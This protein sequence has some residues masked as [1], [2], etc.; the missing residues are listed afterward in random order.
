MDQLH[1]GPIAVPILELARQPV[2][3]L[4]ENESPHL[5]DQMPRQR[6]SPR[7]DL[8]NLVV[9]LGVDRLDDLSLEV[10]IQEEVLPQ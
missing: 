9:G 10:A 1:V 4:D 7:P 6:T 5:A 2:V 8:Q 3:Y